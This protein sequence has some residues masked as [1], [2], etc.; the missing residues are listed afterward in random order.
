[1]KEAKDI[2]D[3]LEFLRSFEKNANETELGALVLQK[4]D[5]R[6]R[7]LNLQGSRLTESNFQKLF[8]MEP[9]KRLQLMDLG[10][11]RMTS[12]GIKHLCVS[13]WLKCLEIL[14][15]ANNNLDDEGV[16]FLSKTI[17]LPSLNSLDLSSNEIGALGAKA[18]SLSKSLNSINSLDLSYNR[19]EALGIHSLAN[20]D[21]GQRLKVLKL[22]DTCLGNEGVKEFARYSLKELEFLDLSENLIS[23]EGVE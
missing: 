17:C 16:F 18:L 21:F 2:D 6:C 9:L 7:S 4:L 23:E 20:S 5:H 10:E 3:S 8:T 1:M 13:K 22:R 12:N 15:L 11:T 14:S 19:I